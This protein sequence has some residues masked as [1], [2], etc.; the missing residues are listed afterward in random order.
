MKIVQEGRVFGRW[1]TPS[2]VGFSLNTI[3][4]TMIAL[5]LH[6]V[7]PPLI[8]GHTTEIAP[9]VLIA[10]ITLALTFTVIGFGLM[11]A[12]ADPFDDKAFPAHKPD[13]D[14]R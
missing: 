11:V 4:W 3:G 2:V 12:G 13:R 1:K 8:Q 7:I 9:V 14:L 6:Q 10:E 5:V